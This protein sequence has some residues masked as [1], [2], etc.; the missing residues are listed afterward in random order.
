M[1]YS[2]RIEPKNIFWSNIKSN[3]IFSDQKL[4]P[5]IKYLEDRAKSSFKDFEPSFESKIVCWRSDDFKKRLYSAE[6][7]YNFSEK[8]F[9]VFP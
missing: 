1:Q 9:K 4:S 3:S 2:V 7:I 5:E 6:N 8:S